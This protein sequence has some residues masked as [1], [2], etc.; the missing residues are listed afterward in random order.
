MPSPPT[1]PPA[2]GEDRSVALALV[3]T[4]IV[5][6]GD[7]V[8]L[9]ADG[10]ALAGWLRRHGLPTDRAA[11]I[12]SSDLHRVHE[13]RT[14]IRQAFTARTEGERPSVGA[15]R[16]INSAAALVPCGSHLGWNGDGPAGRTVWPAGA[17]K[18]D[19]ALAAI[20]QD[21][22]A[23]LLAETGAR[24]RACEAHGCIRLFIQ[25]HARRQW[26]STTCGDRVRVARHYRKVHGRH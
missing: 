17:P 8:D 15:L 7:R 4:E 22:I 25:E 5:R 3:N 6:R 23:T 14:A 16:R 11:A 20:A 1:P 24:L 19:V 12:G 9:L 2:P 26:C 21:A 10:R 18:L 13:L